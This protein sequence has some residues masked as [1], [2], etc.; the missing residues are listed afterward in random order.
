MPISIPTSPLGNFSHTRRP[1]PFPQPRCIRLAW[2]SLR[3]WTFLAPEAASVLSEPPRGFRDLLA[4]SVV[5]R[6]V[7]VG[8]KAK[9]DMISLHGFNQCPLGTGSCLL[10]IV[11]NGISSMTRATLGQSE[12]SGST[13]TMLQ[14]TSSGFTNCRCM[15]Y[16]YCVYFDPRLMDLSPTVWVGGGLAMD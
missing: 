16:L 5:R 7:K 10:C 1:T 13:S 12:G 6:A 4:L 8:F 9:S 2:G 11:I 3:G 14:H 15:M